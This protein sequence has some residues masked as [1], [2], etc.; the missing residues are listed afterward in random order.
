MHTLLL[1]LLFQTNLSVQSTKNRRNKSFS[2]TFIP[3]LMSSFLYAGPS[4]W[5]VSLYLWRTFLILTLFTRQ[6]YLATHSLNFCLRKSL[7]HFRRI[8]L[9][10]L[11]FKGGGVFPLISNIS[12]YSLFVSLGFWEVRCN[13]HLCSLNKVFMSSSF[14]RKA[15]IGERVFIFI[16]HSLNMTCLGVV[17]FFV[18]FCGG[19]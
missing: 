11:E 8:L 17:G 1:L 9:Q 7:Y 12:L 18:V 10:D 15:F 5:S 6:V 2:Y 16:F 4:F 14:W 13:I 3:S 19:F